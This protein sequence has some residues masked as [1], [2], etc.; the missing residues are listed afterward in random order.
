MFQMK[1]VQKIKTYFVICNFFFSKILK[2]R[3][4]TTILRMRISCWIP[5]STDTLTIRNAQVQFQHLWWRDVANLVASLPDLCPSF[6]TFH[7]T[8]LLQSGTVAGTHWTRLIPTSLHT[9]PPFSPS[10]PLIT[11]TEYFLTAW[12]AG[13]KLFCTSFLRLDRV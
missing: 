6:F 9:N 2:G 1:F 4:Q 5:R 11:H 12:C 13:K 8:N 7:L 3:P 10:L